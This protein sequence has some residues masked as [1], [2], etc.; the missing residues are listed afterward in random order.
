MAN[1]ITIKDGSSYA[2]KVK[3]TETNGTHVP[4]HNID[5][6]QGIITSLQNILTEL[7]QN[8]ELPISGSVT[9]TGTPTVNTGLSQS[10]TNSQ[11]RASFVS[12]ELG[13]KNKN[14]TLLKEYTNAAPAS[15]NTIPDNSEFVTLEGWSDSGALEIEVLNELKLSP[16]LAAN[17]YIWVNDGTEIYCLGYLSRYAGENGLS[18]LDS[19]GVLAAASPETFTL[20]RAAAGLKIA[21]VVTGSTTSTTFVV[22]SGIC[23]FSNPGYQGNELVNLAT[24][25]TLPRGLSGTIDSF[26]GSA[27]TVSIGGVSLTNGE[28]CRLN[29]TNIGNSVIPPLGISAR[30]AASAINIA[31]NQFV[32]DNSQ[33]AFSFAV[34]DTVRVRAIAGGTLP[35]VA[36]AA[37][38]ATTTYTVMSVSGSAGSQAITLSTDGLS[39]LQITAPG[40]GLFYMFKYPYIPVYFLSGNQLSY[41]N[42]TP[43]NLV[44]IYSNQSVTVTAGTAASVADT[45]H[46]FTDGQAVT[47]GGTTA[48]GLGFIGM[49]L[50]IRNPTTNAYNLS[51][52]ATGALI[53]FTSAGTSVTL[54]GRSV[55]VTGGTPGSIFLLN[56]FLSTLQPFTLA[57]SVLPTGYLANTV[58][59]VIANGLAANSFQAS[60]R[61]G[62]PPIVYGSTGTSVVLNA[63]SHG[64]FYAIPIEKTQAYV[65]ST[66]LTNTAM[67]F[68][69][70]SG[71][72][73]ITL[74][75]TGSGTHSFVPSA[76]PLLLTGSDI[77]ARSI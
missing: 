8:A 35:S 52:T 7:Q 38:A 16:A 69:N 75:N 56:H 34:G 6:L 47:L 40:Q 32:M 36:G 65:S 64:I 45:A 48:P 58:L 66:G 68:S 13:A 31:T 42:S 5:N 59:N 77:K 20:K 43:I 10:L 62:Y 1:D 28:L 41:N 70:S 57:A 39:I 22:S 2:V 18:V 12:V 63:P 50:F 24:S 60:E 9:I 19:N 23:L 61:N 74:V 33:S 46:P 71:G 26:S 25:G 37:M 29:L 55:V 3:T 15:F 11:L 73:V 30:F 17:I 21:V 72:D 4:H 44:D 51:A 27:D 76:F 54:N 53:A 67:N 14:W 49:T